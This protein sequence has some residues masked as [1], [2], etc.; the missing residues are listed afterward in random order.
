MSVHK[1][2]LLRN[3]A[4]DGSG[5][6]KVQLVQRGKKFYIQFTDVLVKYTQQ[7]NIA[8]FVSDIKAKAWVKN[9]DSKVWQQRIMNGPQ[10][11]DEFGEVVHGLFKVKQHSEEDEEEVSQCFEQEVDS[12][13]W[14]DTTPLDIESVFFAKLVRTTALSC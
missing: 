1:T 7:T 10:F 6:G 2:G 8:L 4:Q 14:P 11:M 3:G 13:E 9:F 12:E 5:T